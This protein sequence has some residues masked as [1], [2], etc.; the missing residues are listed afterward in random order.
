M[1]RQLQSLAWKRGQSLAQLAL[2]WILRKETVTSVIMG[3]S[4]PAQIQDALQVV[5]RTPLTEAEL[6]EIERILATENA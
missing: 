5:N 3:A 2:S 4:K 6:G 1:L